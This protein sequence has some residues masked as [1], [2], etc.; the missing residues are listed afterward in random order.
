MTNKQ[1]QQQQQ[2]SDAETIEMLRKM[3]EV[4]REK[5]Q[6]LTEQMEKLQAD[7]IQLKSFISHANPVFSNHIQAEQFQNLMHSQTREQSTAYQE[8]IEQENYRGEQER[9]LA[10][11]QQYQTYKDGVLKQMPFLQ[12][13]YDRKVAATQL[14]KQKHVEAVER[15]YELSESQ[16]QEY[17][18]IDHT[19]EESAIQHCLEARELEVGVI[20]A[21]GEQ[22]EKRTG[23]II[24][25]CKPCSIIAPETFRS[26]KA[27]EIH[28]YHA[29]HKHDILN[30]IGQAER[31][32]LAE[33][34]ANFNKEVRK[35]VANIQERE[36]R[37]RLVREHKEAKQREQ[38]AKDK[39]PYVT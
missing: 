21:N 32:T 11:E 12:Q 31:K 35:E 10:L 18:K 28:C 36:R 24:Y 17:V 16:L 7:H 27:A 30:L 14:E 29:D 23:D 6:K 8:Q 22:V 25:D 9:Q 3:L 34:T 13:E 15:F 19:L 2:T 38:S 39:L 4:S 33:I 1:S 5:N 20:N 37:E 26:L